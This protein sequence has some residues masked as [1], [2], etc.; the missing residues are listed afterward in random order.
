MKKSRIGIALTASFILIAL[1]ALSINIFSAPEAV[2]Q[3]VSYSVV[4]VKDKEGNFTD[5]GFEFLATLPEGYG[6][7]GKALYNQYTHLDFDVTAGKVV[8]G[9]LQPMPPQYVTLF[10]RANFLQGAANAAPIVIYEKGKRVEKLNLPRKR[11]TYSM[12]DDMLPRGFTVSYT[13]VDNTKIDVDFPPDT[14]MY[15]KFMS[16]CRAQMISKAQQDYMQNN[17]D[18]RCWEEP[19]KCKSK[20]Q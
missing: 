2:A 6:I 11:V 12:I 15:G 18:A 5:C 14:A 8:G 7:Q 20:K 3:Q 17:K 13:A 19:E 1:V 16:G 9:A 4:E 10:V